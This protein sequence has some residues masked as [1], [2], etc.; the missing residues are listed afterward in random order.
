[1]NTTSHAWTVREF[2]PA[3]MNKNKGHI[4]TIASAAG[5]MGVCGLSDYCAS[6]FGAFG[7][8]ESL[9]MELKQ[10]K[11]SVK[12]TVICPFYINTGMF[13]GVKTRFPFLLPILEEKWAADRIVN[14]VLQNEDVVLMPWF[15]NLTF[16]M[17]GI[18]PVWVFDWMADFLGANSSM[19][20]FKGRG[21][22]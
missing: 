18:L 8:N 15:T 17:R 16:V 21:G 5:T 13:E 4:V 1:M 2:L 9:R 11:S 3:M 12:T 19:E 7:F 20:E 22:H 10:Q 14:A 6:K